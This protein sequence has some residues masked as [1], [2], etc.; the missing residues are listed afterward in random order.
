MDTIQT[1]VYVQSL[2]NFTCR[3]WMMKGETLLIFGH[4]VI[5]QGQL[6]PPARGCHA[7]RCLVIVCAVK[8]SNH[9]TNKKHFTVDN[10]SPPYPS[11]ICTYGGSDIL[12]SWI[13]FLKRA[14]IIHLSYSLEI[15][16]KKNLFTNG[17]L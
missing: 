7:L 12:P 5:G 2:S 11:T 16:I 17:E 4:G 14:T 13:F 10:A 8:W 1:T 15:F 9:T 6:C 3:L